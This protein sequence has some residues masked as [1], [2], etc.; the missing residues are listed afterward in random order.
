MIVGG[1]LEGEQRPGLRFINCN[2]KARKQAI[3]I[4]Q[5]SEPP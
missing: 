3:S 2:K 4:N 1:E 5:Y